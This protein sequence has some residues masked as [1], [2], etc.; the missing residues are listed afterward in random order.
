MKLRT[1]Y[2]HLLPFRFPRN[3]G[4]TRLWASDCER[5]IDTARYFSAGFFGFNWN[6]TATLHIIPETAELGADTLTPGDTCLT[7]LEDK[8]QGHDK[9]A[10]MLAEYRAN[11]IR[12]IRVR[13][14]RQNPG[15]NFTDDEIYGMQEMCGFE[16]TVRGS[17][18]WCD[19][20]TKDEFLSFEYARDVIHYYRSGPGTLYGGIMGWLWL[21]AT[22]NLLLEGPSAGPFFFSL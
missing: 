10:V 20:F 19:I 3:G 22:T 11:Y 4:K 15:I 14:S 12:A 13:L 18:H 21:N 7:Y 17:S 9:G 8:E 1:R 6:D 5:V 2:H 16:I